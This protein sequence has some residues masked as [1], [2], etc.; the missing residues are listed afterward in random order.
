MLKHSTT[1]HRVL[2]LLLLGISLTW[3]NGC[4]NV[5]RPPI[6]DRSAGPAWTPDSH[7]VRAGETLYSIAFQYG[8]RH[9]TLAQWN[10][11]R[12]PY[13]IKVGQTLRLKP[14]AK[15]T[16]AASRSSSS[17]S[18]SSDSVKQTPAPTTTR[19]SVTPPLQK[20]SPITWQWPAQGPIL[21]TYQGNSH[22][23]KGIEIGGARGQAVR[24]AAAGR[25]VYAGSGLVGYGRLI[26][27]K[28]DARFLSAYGFNDTLFV[29]E[30]S[31]V[32]AGQV[33]AEMGSSGTNR[34]QLHFEIRRD[35]KPVDPLQY[36]PKR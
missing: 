5:A 9:E 34:V 6:S 20:T 33:I 24:A 14:S 22:G 32:H 13:T 30:G 10:G 28:H 8:M 17:T 21:R 23:K 15:P 11:L 26:I 2:L 18:A 31:Q 12:S 7:R 19:P 3:L 36:L 4:S 16:G 25:V 1:A 29:Q 27:I 35:G